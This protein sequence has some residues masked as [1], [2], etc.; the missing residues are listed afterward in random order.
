MNQRTRRMRYLENVYNKYFKLLN[1][2]NIILAKSWTLAIRSNI[3][4]IIADHEMIKIKV[5]KYTE[6][7]IYEDKL[8]QKCN[9]VGIPTEEFKI[10]K[11]DSIK[12]L[13]KNHPVHPSSQQDLGRNRAMF[14]THLN[15]S[16]FRRN[17]LSQVKKED[18]SIDDD[19]WN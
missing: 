19:E 12:E 5:T 3:L 8:Q 4:D 16:I 6:T 13:F 11:G 9:N 14:I 2:D 18:G 10:L 15:T 17:Q 1:S 7:Q